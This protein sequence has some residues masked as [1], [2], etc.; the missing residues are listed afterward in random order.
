[1]ENTGASEDLAKAMVDKLLD[2]GNELN[3]VQDSVRRLLVQ[4]KPSEKLVEGVEKMNKM[5]VAGQEVMNG[6]LQWRDEMRTHVSTFERQVEQHEL[7]KGMEELKME[8]REHIAFGQTIRKEIHYKYFVGKPLIIIV[9]LV[10]LVGWLAAAWIGEQQ[11]A[12]KHAAND[13]K[14]QYMKSRY[15]WRRFTDSV[16][17]WYRAD[18]KGMEKEVGD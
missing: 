8:I 13:V 2:I 9:L 12:S 15:E 5:A 3:E 4:Q 17:S 11:E 18:P 10:M 1:M 16:E 7:K 6:I 14:W